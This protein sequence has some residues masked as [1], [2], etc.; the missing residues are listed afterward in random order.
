MANLDYYLHKDNGEIVEERNHICFAMCGN[1]IA[2]QIR[3]LEYSK[4]QLGTHLDKWKP[5][6]LRAGRTHFSYIVARV[7]VKYESHRWF[8]FLL[9]LPV[10]KDKASIKFI[11]DVCF[12]DKHSPFFHAQHTDNDYKDKL[13]RDFVGYYEITVS[14]NSLP[15]QMTF[16]LL[17]MVRYCRDYDHIVKNFDMLC[18]K[19][20]HP[21]LSFVLAQQSSRISMPG[22]IRK[23]GGKEIVMMRRGEGGLGHHSLTVY[24]AQSTELIDMF[25]RENYVGKQGAV[26]TLPYSIH[27]KIP[28]N[29][30]RFM[31]PGSNGKCTLVKQ[32]RLM[33]DG[34]LVYNGGESGRESL[35]Y[36]DKL[37]IPELNACIEQM[38]AGQVSTATVAPPP[39]RKKAAKALMKKAKTTVKKA[40]KQVSGYNHDTIGWPPFAVRTGVPNERTTLMNFILSPKLIHSTRIREL[41][42]VKADTNIGKP[43]LRKAF[44]SVRYY[45]NERQSYY[46]ASPAL[47]FGSLYRRV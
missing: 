42:N 28:N 8:D 5:H 46:G 39:Q 31:E 33:E 25:Y 40:I 9:N 20:L 1:P 3:R 45:N 27:M 13:K 30:I 44:P 15:V 47:G 14:L 34:A 23:W 16:S 41:L 37:R 35:L 26:D 6:A 11:K 12:D 22:G 21:Y 4:S 19:G 7:P 10:Y 38:I 2:D 36:V 18:D 29:K 43:Q 17:S 32:L 24:S